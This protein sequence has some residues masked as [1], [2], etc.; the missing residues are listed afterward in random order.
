VSIEKTQR[1]FKAIAMIAVLISGVS[2][3]Y[4][5]STIGLVRDGLFYREH[6]MSTEMLPFWKELAETETNKN[7]T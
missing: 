6:I 4:I 7:T 3:F 5:F 2:I 1:S